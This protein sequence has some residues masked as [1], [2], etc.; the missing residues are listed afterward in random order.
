MDAL[1]QTVS[2]NLSNLA[3]A[4]R[5]G[6]KG[7]FD[8]TKFTKMYTDVYNATV[9]TGKK[10]PRDVQQYI[11]RWC[12]KDLTDNVLA[13][14]KSIP[15]GDEG[16]TKLFAAVAAEYNTFHQVIKMLKYLFLQTDQA[17]ASKL[18]A[19]PKLGN[20]GGSV[21][22]ALASVGAGGGGGAAMASASRPSGSSSSSSGTSGG[23]LSLSEQSAL[24]AF[25]DSVFQPVEARLRNSIFDQLD[26]I[27][28]GDAHVDQT[29]VKS[30]TTL[31]EK[32]AKVLCV[33]SVDRESVYMQSFARP[34]FQRVET[35]VHQD[36]ITHGQ[37]ETYVEFLLARRDL[38]G[39]LAKICLNAAAAFQAIEVFDRC[40]VERRYS[41]IL[42]HPRFGLEAYLEPDRFN[43]QAVA[44]LYKLFFK[45]TPTKPK[46]LDDF[47]KSFGNSITK[48]MHSLTKQWEES[49]T[50]DT[51]LALACKVMEDVL[52]L[53]R[54]K[55]LVVKN[56]FFGNVQLTR[57]RQTSFVHSLNPLQ[58][59]FVTVA[60]MSKNPSLPAPSFVFAQLLAHYVDHTLR[61]LANSSGGGG[62]VASSVVASSSSS[63]SIGGGG[64]SGWADPI[65]QLFALIS[66]K[67]LFAEYYRLQMSRRLLSATYVD[68]NERAVLS[69]LQ[70][71]N[72]KVYTHKFEGMLNDVTQAAQLQDQFTNAYPN[73][74]G[75]VGGCEFSTRVL[76]AAYWPTIRRDDT[77]V[78]PESL[79]AC[80]E[81]FGRFY[82]KNYPTRQLRW[83]AER[84]WAVLVAAFPKG[85]KEITCNI[86]QAAVM[87]AIDEQ[88]SSSSASSSSNNSVALSMQE[89]ARRTG[90]AELQELKPI[91]ASMLF[92][93][94]LNLIRRGN[95]VD[96][97]AKLLDSDSFE[98]NPDYT[99]KIRKLK[100]PNAASVRS[101][102]GGNNNNG[103]DVDTIT[104]ETIDASRAQMLDAAIV[105]IMKS[106]KELRIQEIVDLTIQSVQRF[107]VAQPRAIKKRV[108]ALMQK[109]FLERD[110]EDAEI[111]RY[112]A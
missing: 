88:A 32:I 37:S 6:K 89:L 83:Q 33:T 7:I 104:E 29:A 91:I 92:A 36:Y 11:T 21:A 96:V 26:K 98:M 80:Q 75:L 2:P 109:E 47:S 17:V 60:S 103:G 81:I 39:Y 55:D 53:L 112:L 71:Q 54:N 12:R 73:A 57:Q 78:L 43:P 100:L 19:D 14:L 50:F 61:E 105:R 15:V 52:K 94:G 9:R 40:A 58:S 99:M 63:S 56:E 77:F 107:F 106:R 13:E 35:R 70:R 46:I 42:A 93:K 10:D 85:S 66:D 90:I 25:Y 48:D 49:T 79:V 3:K 59:K 74:A 31:F 27:R 16:D 108:E 1:D 97:K 110:E 20:G 8:P 68:D 64:E 51:V 18:Q 82:R 101:G 87:I 111:F 65:S 62:A 22:I 44:R 5:T 69:R 30:A 76:T 34:Y 23:M 28:D 24:K 86:Y 4:L 38:E 45:M 67:D 95:S 102:G 41:E 72:G 84:G